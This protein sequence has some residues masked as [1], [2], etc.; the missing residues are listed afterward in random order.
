MTKD[1]LFCCPEWRLRQ[2]VVNSLRWPGVD[3]LDCSQPCNPGPTGHRELDCLRR[4]EQ[5]RVERNEEA[6]AG[7]IDSQI[8]KTS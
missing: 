5:A 6:T 4:R 3:L 1:I 2:Y 8:V 7:V